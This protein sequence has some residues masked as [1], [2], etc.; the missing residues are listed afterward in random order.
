MGHKFDIMHS[1]KN[2]V[3][4]RHK[5]SK[6]VFLIE[7]A[8]LTEFTLHEC[9][10]ESMYKRHYKDLGTYGS[11]IE[12]AMSLSSIAVQLEAGKAA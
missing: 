12:A 5:A 3:I 4:L 2:K 10:F 1:S 9:T 7:R 8:S 11:Q 6:I